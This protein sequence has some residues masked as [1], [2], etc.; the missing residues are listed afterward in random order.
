[1][2]NDHLIMPFLSS[3]NIACG[4][5]FGNRESMIEAIDLAKRYNVKVGAH[6]SFADEEG[7]GRNEIYVPL[8]QL[9]SQLIHQI[10]LLNELVKGRGMVLNHVKAHGALYNLAAR[11]SKYAMILIETMKFFK[12]PWYL[13]VPYGS[14]L[15]RKAKAN[16]IKV[17]TEVFA[18]RRY[19]DDL[20]LLSRTEP[21]AVIHKTSQIKEQVK[22]LM[23]AG[24]IK[25]INGNKQQVKPD[26][27]CIHGD[28]PKAVEIA[29]MINKI[30]T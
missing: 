5:H 3:C 15:E 2:G 18:D 7:F 23:V 17:K 9:K 12:E 22:R 20:S 27:I 10:A 19:N 16:G 25:T 21:E 14:V 28:H 30:K 6:P 13:Y 24:E 11:Y 4:G 26:T 29:K 1:M 8:D